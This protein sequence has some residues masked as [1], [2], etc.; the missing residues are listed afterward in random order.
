MPLLETLVITPHRVIVVDDDPQL[1]DR[2]RAAGIEAHR[3]DAT[4]RGL[5]RRVGA[6]DARVIVSTVTRIE[7]NEPLLEE[8]RGVPIF[9]RAFEDAEAEWLTAHGARPVGYG[10]AAADSFLEWFD[11]RGWETADDLADAELEDVL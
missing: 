3:G 4:N 7:D 9:V 10:D 6:S 11:R 1:V 5:L 8:A 2:I